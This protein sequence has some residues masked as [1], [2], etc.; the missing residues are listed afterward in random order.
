MSM[1]VRALPLG[2]ALAGLSI[3]VVI[4]SSATAEPSVPLEAAD[5]ETQ[6]PLSPNRFYVHF[7]PGA[8]VFDAGARVK[9]GGVVI[10]GATVT[11]D[12]DVTLITEFGYRWQS[13]GLS[14]TGGYPPVATVSGAGSL[15]PLGSLGR[16]CYGPTVRSVASMY[17]TARERPCS[18]ARSFICPVLGRYSSTPR[19]RLSRPMPPLFWE[20]RPSARTSD[21]T[22]PSYPA[23]FPTA[24]DRCLRWLIDGRHG[25][26]YRSES[27]FNNAGAAF[28]NAEKASRCSMAMPFAYSSHSESLRRVKSCN[29][30]ARS[31][32][33]E[34]PVYHDAKSRGSGL[35]RKPIL[36]PS[37]RK[38]GI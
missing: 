14:L 1:S 31:K 32:Q 27:R 36:C 16:I 34:N 19:R 22:Q 4:G 30:C 33:A 23:A 12:P 15:A 24:S 25:V 38:I 10:P 5:S 35:G 13:F 9:S 11:I 2:A 28:N 29:S 6:E 20:A 8:L 37:E 21:L 17:T 26:Y 7:G 3:C 18:S